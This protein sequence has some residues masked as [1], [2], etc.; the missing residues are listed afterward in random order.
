MTPH[1]G[2]DAQLRRLE[3]RVDRERRARV[4]AEQLLENK[5]LELYRANEALSAAAAELEG[6]VVERT[7]ELNEERQRALCMA[8]RDELTAIANRAAFNRELRQALSRN[9]EHVAVLLIDLDDFKQVNDSLGHAAGDALLVEIAR[10]LVESVRPGDVVAR[11]GGDEFAVL[12][13]RLHEPGAAL[14]LAE[15]LLQALG[16]PATIEGRQVPCSCSIGLADW[17][18]GSAGDLLRDADMALYAS[19]RAG[20]H[21][22]TSFLPSMR[23]EQERRNTH[24]SAVR[25]AVAQGHIVPWYQPFIRTNSGR[26]VGAE[27][28]ARWHAPGAAVRLPSDFLELVEEMGLLDKMM[29]T[30]LHQALPEAASLISH[31]SLEYLTVNVSALQF[32]EGWATKQLVQLID[33]TGFP[34]SALVVELTETALL[35]DM[36]RAR[37]MLTQLRAKG[38]RIAIDDFGVGYSNFSL[39]RQLPFD[40]LKLDRSLIC[41]IETDT[42][43]YAVTE[44]LLQLG[45]RL[46]IKTVAE[47]VETAGQAERLAAVSCDAMQGYRFARP[48]RDLSAWFAP[49]AAL[50]CSP[51]LASP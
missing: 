37:D 30:M 42:H 19:K 11:L 9:G 49:G 12:A 35:S 39:L 3:A 13:C 33:E 14:V 23:T 50:P 17:K 24:E 43:A 6:R 47:G 16:R 34:P 25:A 32:S 28:L 1:S 2:V 18:E 15:R 4:E 38:I 31:G 45:Q 8:E 36:V 44:C 5:S 22:V 29:A 40:I 20:R 21:C 10:R 26:F 7:R 48:Q 27:L 46:R 41:D 51:W